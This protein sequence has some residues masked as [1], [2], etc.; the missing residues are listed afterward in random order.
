MKPRN[1]RSTFPQLALTLKQWRVS[2]GKKLVTVAAELGFS[3]AAW[4]HWERG[5]RTPSAPSLRAISD[6]TGLPVHQ[7]LCPHINE[8][9][10]VHQ[11]DP[12][13]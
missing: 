6:Y 4:G 12:N 11:T 13:T 5:I 1:E 9:P 2:N 3:T 8:C 10:F 7:L